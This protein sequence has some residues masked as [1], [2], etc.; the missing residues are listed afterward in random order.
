MIWLS[1]NDAELFINEFNSKNVSKNVP[2]WYMQAESDV[3]PITLTDIQYQ[4]LKIWLSE[5][6]K[7]V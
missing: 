5:L 4:E 6:T 1:I 7:I 3:L 2:D